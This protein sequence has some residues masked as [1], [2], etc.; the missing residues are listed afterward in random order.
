MEA[1][2]LVMLGSGGVGKSALT[3]RLI[4][5]NFLEEYDPTIE[6]SYQK[7]VNIDGQPALIEVLDTAG[8]EEYS[9]MQDQW[10][11]DGQAF[12][13]IYS[14]TDEKTFQDLRNIR[15]KLFRIKDSTAVPMYSCK[16]YF[17]VVILMVVSLYIFYQYIAY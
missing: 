16:F 15:E 13:L 6:D 3:I 7:N 8:Q 9:S 5:D 11:R 10:M 12:L 14:I 4:T 1:I 17:E 2:R